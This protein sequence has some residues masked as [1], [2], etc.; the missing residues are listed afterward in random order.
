MQL[1]IGLGS[2][3]FDLYKCPSYICLQLFLGTGSLSLELFECPSYIC[4]QLFLGTGSLSLELF[5]CPSYIRLQLFLGLGFPYEGPA[6]L[7]AIAL[8]AV[9]INPSF[10]PPHNSQNTKFFK[11]KPTRRKVSRSD[12]LFVAKLR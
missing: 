8:G 1:Y 12:E 10:D 4:L 11:D 9:F 5:E 7:E 3:S 2:L 6:P